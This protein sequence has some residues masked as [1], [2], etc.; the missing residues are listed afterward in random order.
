MKKHAVALVVAAIVLAMGIGS[1]SAR[2]TRQNQSNPAS[3]VSKKIN[4]ELPR[5]AGKMEREC[6]INGSCTYW[7]CYETDEQS[8]CQKIT[9]CNPGGVCER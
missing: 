3:G 1:A 8:V 2:D 7:D 4:A 5:P 6:D 9:W